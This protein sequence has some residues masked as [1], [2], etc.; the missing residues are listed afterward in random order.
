V[1]DDTRGREDYVASFLCHLDV[2]RVR[3]CLV[4]RP[5]YSCIWF[6][7]DV[8]TFKSCALDFW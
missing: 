5:K 4:L 2:G 8:A 7:E 6:E 3:V 1:I